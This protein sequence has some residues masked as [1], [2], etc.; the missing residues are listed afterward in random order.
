MTLEM[1]VQGSRSCRTLAYPRLAT[2]HCATL[3]DSILVSTYSGFKF[4]HIFV[5]D[6]HSPFL[7]THSYLKN[8]CEHVLVTLWMPT[9]IL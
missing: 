6:T 3:W 7:C 4:D 2:C 9:Q 1:T 8:R 5:G